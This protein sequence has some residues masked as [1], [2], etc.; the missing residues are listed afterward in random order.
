MT[1]GLGL[2]RNR[3][4]NQFHSRI[5]IPL[6]LQH[7]L[8]RR[9]IRLSLGTEQR[10]CAI[11]AARLVHAEKIPAFDELRAE[12]DKHDANTTPERQAQARQRLLARLKQAQQA[13]LSIDP[14]EAAADAARYAAEA[15]QQR[16]DR[17]VLE[18]LDSDP[19]A[20][21]AYHEVMRDQIAA[22][23]AA[24]TSASNTLVSLQATEAAKNAAIQV[25]ATNINRAIEAEQRAEKSEATIG[26]MITD[27]A[28]NT[29]RM[30]TKHADQLTS[31]TLAALTRPGMVAAPEQEEIKE[32]P[33]IPFSELANAWLARKV[34]DRVDESGAIRPEGENRLRKYRTHIDRFLWAMGDI[35]TRCIN[36]GVIEQ[37]WEIEKK[38]PSG[39]RIE[40]HKDMSVQEVIKTTKN[41]VGLDGMKNIVEVVS[42]TISYILSFGRTDDKREW[43]VTFA[44]DKNPVILAKAAI[45]N[46]TAKSALKQKLLK[47]NLT[48]DE[49]NLYFNG[50]SSKYKIREFSAAHEYWLPL[51]LLLSGARPNEICQLHTSDIKPDT[52]NTLCFSINKDDGKRLKHAGS[53]ARMVPV[54]PRLIELGFLDFVEH[55]RKIGKTHLFHELK[56]GKKDTS[57]ANINNK[58]NQA[59]EAAGIQKKT[60]SGIATMYSFRATFK[61]RLAHAGVQKA[62]RS[63]ITGE[64]L[65]SNDLDRTYINSLEAKKKLQSMQ[66]VEWP[67]GLFDI[68]PKWQ[69][70]KIKPVKIGRPR[71]NTAA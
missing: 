27:H 66:L 26:R 39:F 20:R 59:M 68:F 47:R 50:P 41:P 56:H 30:A 7:L 28:T 55:A 62:I 37:F 34:N 33:P 21:A 1:A 23:Y 31:L 43:Q 18:L 6:D 58:M 17:E 48:D 63:L 60:S 32:A 70:I 13:I 11:R 64:E 40:I 53:A 25:A 38:L 24:E 9:E 51:T 42:K 19:E 14:Q 44:H 52:D 10:R 65:P 22:R 45:S 49:I 67:D 16:E 4:G 8:G 54:D 69:D 57:Y 46:F 29:A 35:P 3:H 5:C 12:M 61:G 15:D 71:K 36:K 2:T